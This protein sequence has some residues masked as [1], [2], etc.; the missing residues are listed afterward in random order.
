VRRNW[1]LDKDCFLRRYFPVSIKDE[2]ER[3]VEF[4]DLPRN[5]T[6]VLDFVQQVAVGRGMEVRRR[7]VLGGDSLTLHG[8]EDGELLVIPYIPEEPMGSVR[9]MLFE[10]P[11]LNLS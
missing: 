9:V 7:E 3:A 8:D 2:I 11:E 10:M 5:E 4:E 6:G 1:V